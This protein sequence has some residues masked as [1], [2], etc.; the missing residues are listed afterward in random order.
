MPRVVFVND[1]IEISAQTGVALPQAALEA[2]ASLPFGCRSGTCGTCVCN[3]VR[4]DA[5]LDDMGFVEKD[6]LE[7]LGFAAPARRLACQIILK[8]EEIHIT[9]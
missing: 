7:V 3:V 6:T 8:D 2:G 4:G 5:Y 1:S 9:W